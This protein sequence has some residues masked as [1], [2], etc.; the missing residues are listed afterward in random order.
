MKHILFILLLTAN[1]LHAQTRTAPITDAE[2]IK[3][4]DVAYTE[5]TK[6]TINSFKAI[7]HYA[8]VRLHFRK[9]HECNV[10]IRK[11]KKP[12]Q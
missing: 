9:W 7:R 5:M 11:L 6:N 8:I 3:E 10:A 2:Y 12:K 4:R 1:C